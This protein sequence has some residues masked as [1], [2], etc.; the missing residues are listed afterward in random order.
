[1][2]GPNRSADGYRPDGR[3]PATVQ[4]PP[5][6]SLA[7]R[8]LLVAT[9]T[10]GRTQLVGLPREGGCADIRAALAVSIGLGAE[11]H[12]IAPAA[13]AVTG[14]APGHH[15][16]LAAEKPL[17]VGESGTLARL[18]TA[19]AGLCGQ[20]ELEVRAAGSLLQRG[21]PALFAALVRSGV[22]L[23]RSPEVL[24]DGWPVTLRAR[25]PAPDLFLDQP[26]SSQELSALFLVAAAYPDAIQVH[27]EGPIPS[28]PYV[29]LTTGLLRRFGVDVQTVLRRTRT[30][31][32]FEVRGVLTPPEAPIA[33]EPDAS[34]AAVA[35]AAGAIRGCELR[36]PGDFRSSQ[37]GD[38]EIVRCLQAFGVET[39]LDSRGLWTRG[40]VRS[41]AALDLR[42]APDLAPPLVAVAVAAS[43]QCGESS[44]LTGLEG[45]VHKE[46]D[47]LRVLARGA[48]ALGVAIEADAERG[49]LRVGDASSEPPEEI[50]LDPENDHRMAF[51]FALFGLVRDGVTVATPEVV[52]KSWPTFW[53]DL[54]PR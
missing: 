17:E 19:V 16:G 11:H 25:G 28:F 41:G 8:A 45:L 3:L 46:S 26:R 23:A 38:L 18:V 44:L 7:Q 54:R 40:P 32:S 52:Q 2:S 42:D 22:S 53:A 1:M 51:A 20:G 14:K 10:H 9:L 27:V 43:L 6:K 35:L 21:S 12:W 4:V 34:A 31:N 47:R 36:V 13:L 33:I 5:S 48:E 49:I 30:C 24:A 15:G 50:H 29:R 37:Q 39:G